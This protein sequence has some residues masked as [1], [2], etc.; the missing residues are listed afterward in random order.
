MTSIPHFGPFEKPKCKEFYTILPEHCSKTVCLSDFI[1]SRQPAAIPQEDRM[2]VTGVI[3]EYNPF[4]RGHAYH[5]ARTRALSK[6][7]YVVCVMSGSVTQR[8]VFARHDKWTRAR[9]ALMHGADLV[10]ELPVRFACA[11]AQ[12]FAAGGVGLLSSLGVCTHLSFGC[13]RDA[14][15]LLD[16]A[17]AVLGEESPE[18]RDALRRGLDAGLPYPKAR[19]DALQAVCG[20][21]SLSSAVS[22]PNAALALEYLQALPESIL[23]VPVLREGSG[24]HDE[25][26]AAL[27]SAT[28]VR[29]AIAQ[30]L[31][32]Q[33][34]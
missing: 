12:E 20:T 32:P 6:A 22:Q 31:F 8:G 14:L 3:C 34:R 29:R 9:M 19:A 13:E 5:L 23:P 25:Q 16:K 17:R 11:S 30:G 26:L 2:R 24:Y 28:A 7:D 10:L 1:T 15:P 33:G 21:D 18:F 4:H 27:S